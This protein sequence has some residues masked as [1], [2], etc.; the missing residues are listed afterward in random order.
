MTWTL[1]GIGMNSVKL[2]MLE[3]TQVA[4]RTPE[5][6]FGSGAGKYR[7]TW[8]YMTQGKW[9]GK[10]T[11]IENEVD[12]TLLKNPSGFLPE[13]PCKRTITIFADRKRRDVCLDSVPQSLFKKP[14]NESVK[15]RRVA[16]VS[17]QKRKRM[18]E[19]RS[20][21]T[22]YPLNKRKPMGKPK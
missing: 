17:S 7:T 5:L 21:M 14:R 12:W 10:W 15:V 8:T 18:L 9:A 1:G 11:R 4:F 6:G 19:K 16:A 3:R 22:R 13:L 20:H 2:F